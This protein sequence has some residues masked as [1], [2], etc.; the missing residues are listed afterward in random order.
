MG[1]IAF[2][3]DEMMK[4]V[5]E[6]GRERDKTTANNNKKIAHD[7]IWPFTNGT[8]TIDRMD[9]IRNGI[10][11]HY[12]G[13]KSESSRKKA[14]GVTKRFLNNFFDDDMSRF[15]KRLEQN[16]PRSSL[17]LNQ[18]I[19]EDEDIRNVIKRIQRDEDRID[20]K[21]QHCALF[22]FL[23][24]TGMRPA[25][26]QK[27][28]VGDF[29]EALTTKKPCLIIDSKIDKTLTEHY[30]PLHPVVVK[31]LGEVIEGKGDNEPV[32]TS[33]T[34]LQR[35]LRG[36]QT[37]MI[38]QPKLKVEVRDCRKFMI[39]KSKVELK[40]NPE[41]LNYIVGHNLGGIDPKYY[42][43]YKR[44]VFYDEY[45]AAWGPIDLIDGLEPRNGESPMLE[46]IQSLESTIADVESGQTTEE[47]LTK[48]EDTITN[49][50]NL[51]SQVREYNRGRE[52]K[53]D[54]PAELPSMKSIRLW[55]MADT[56]TREIYQSQDGVEECRK[57]IA[58]E[59]FHKYYNIYYD[60]RQNCISRGLLVEK[61]VSGDPDN[62][63]VVYIR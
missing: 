46:V 21:K 61:I 44:E 35:L 59:Y 8:I 11:A 16:K 48:I 42:T 19:L 14:L 57:T 1:E 6:I 63:N 30:V 62:R 58:H 56:A 36:S 38:N 49:T 39:Q 54:F 33:Y 2:S 13:P 53:I 29:R 41:I 31:V 7:F 22:T 51:I 5:F 15:V 28:K 50:S 52:D 18:R 12:N 4:W 34:L 60:L 3:Y 43:G 55:I 32:F 45:M 47:I 23:A 9:A 24:Y 20:I 37:P 10:Y 17:R 27:L 26:A 25:T 40:L